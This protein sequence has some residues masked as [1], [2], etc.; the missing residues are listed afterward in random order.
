MNI[1]LA[2]L[3]AIFY[4]LWGGLHI[5]AAYKVYALG[6]TLDP[7]MVQAR[8]FQNASFLLFFAIFAIA[9]AIAFNWKNSPLGFW[10]NLII[11]S[12]ADIGF[13][14]FVLVPGYI[15]PVPGAFGPILW[16]LAAVTSAVAIMAGSNRNSTES[17]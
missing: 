12:A 6:Q 10:L 17:T 14:F 16:I 15:P 9:V 8:L 4:I 7:G 11:V 3:G 1:L 2:R 13:I 5:M